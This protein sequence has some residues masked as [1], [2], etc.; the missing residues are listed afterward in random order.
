VRG[1]P[2]RSICDRYRISKAMVQKMLSEW[3]MRA[4]AGGYI[5]DIHPEVIDV[6]AAELEV[7]HREAL[8]GLLDT[9]FHQEQIHPNQFHPEMTGAEVAALAELAEA[10]MDSSKISWPILPGR[11]RPDSPVSVAGGR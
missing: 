5:Q 10:A 6:M 4:I 7:R 3:R 9:Q 11:A 2:I 8:V 1:W